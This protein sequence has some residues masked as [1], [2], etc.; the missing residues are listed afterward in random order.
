MQAAKRCAAL[1]AAMVLDRALREPPTRLHPVAWFGSAMGRVEAV[2][3]RDCRRAGVAYTA[4]GVAAAGTVGVASRRL[5][6]ELGT[7]AVTAVAVAG[8]ELRRTAARV[9]R[10]LEDG[11]LPEA[12]LALRS[13]AGRDPSTLDESGVAAA[14]IESLA[15]NTVDAAVATLGWAFVGG[16]A[17][18]AVHRAVN[19]MD[20][21]VGHHS[22]RYERFGWASARLDDVMAWV[23]ARLFAV[24]VAVVR[25]SRA[26]EVARVVRRDARAHPSPNAGVAEAAVAAALGLQ[27]GGPLRYGDRVE[28]RPT[29]GDGPRPTPADVGRAIRL[30]DDVER[31]LWCALVTVALAGSGWWGRLGRGSRRGR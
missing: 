31:L 8:N 12:R 17:G 15:E 27:L 26:R 23:P 5:G 21:M 25:P 30:V 4:A 9:G 18:A 2:V 1:A 7:V 24:A 20:A 6:G 3:W 28:H 11:E 22:T 19:T 13:L 14:V 29:L 10:M 16:A